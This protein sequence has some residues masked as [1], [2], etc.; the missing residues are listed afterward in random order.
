MH[1]FLILLNAIVSLSSVVFAIVA[2]V[3]PGKLSGSEH[4]AFGEQYYARLYA[5]RSAPL[6]LASALVPIATSGD[7]AFL[8]LLAAAAIQVADAIVAVAGAK[9]NMLIGAS[10]AAIIHLACAFAIH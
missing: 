6:E 9:R 3:M 5:V 4:V 8:L 10:G 2:L 1:A 7:A